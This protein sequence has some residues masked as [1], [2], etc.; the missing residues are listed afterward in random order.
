MNAYLMVIQTAEDI[1]LDVMVLSP[2]TYDDVQ[3]VL[4]EKHFHVKHEVSRYFT[5]TSLEVDDICK[6]S[7]DM[8]LFIPRHRQ[9]TV[10]AKGGKA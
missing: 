2:L 7:P 5:V 1:R 9:I 3:R 8:V 4:Q 10:Y 6:C